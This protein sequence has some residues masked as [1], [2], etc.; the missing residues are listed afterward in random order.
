MN[1]FGKAILEDRYEERRH[2]YARAPLLQQAIES[3]V[4]LDAAIKHLA[5]P[6]GAQPLSRLSTADKH[7]A[8]LQHVEHLSRMPTSRW[9]GQTPAE[10]I[11]G[12]FVEAKMPA[13]ARDSIF[14]KARKEADLT[15]PAV[16]WVRHHSKIVREE[17]PMGTKR[18]DVV[19]YRPGGF[20]AAAS[21]VTIEL[22]NDINQL[23]R[24]LDQMTSYLDYSTLVYLACTPRLAAEYLKHHASAPGVRRWEPDALQRKLQKFGFGLLLIEGDAVYEVHSPRGTGVRPIHLQ[25]LENWLSAAQQ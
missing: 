9:Y 3:S 15:A 22:K 14:P 6:H 16:N 19:G 5:V 18:A 12:S 17:V 8:I 1:V 13:S 23:N 10:I 25:S 4:V 2:A 21:V 20:F 24:G 7:A 11:A